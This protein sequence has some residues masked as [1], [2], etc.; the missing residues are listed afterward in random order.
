VGSIIGF[1][2]DSKTVVHMPPKTS[3]RPCWI[4][5]LQRFRSSGV[6]SCCYNYSY[7]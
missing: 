4:T 5:L 6:F 2:R 7:Y 3:T 1:R